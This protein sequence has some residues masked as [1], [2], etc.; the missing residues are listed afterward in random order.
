[1]YRTIGDISTY[2]TEHFKAKI[3]HHYNAFNQYYKLTIERKEFKLFKRRILLK[4]IIRVKF[5]WKNFTKEGG[6]FS[7]TP[8]QLEAS[9]KIHLIMNTKL[10]EFELNYYNE[11]FWKSKFKKL[12]I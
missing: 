10:K 9:S 5:R 2:K 1:M 11:D 8:E 7:G 4:A 6:F 3:Y 12:N